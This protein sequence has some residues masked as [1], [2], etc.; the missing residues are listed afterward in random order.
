MAVTGR[1]AQM[2][3]RLAELLKMER[4]DVERIVH[5]AVAAHTRAGLLDAVAAVRQVNL[6]SHH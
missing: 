4:M 5:A 3:R 1:L 6:Q 2:L